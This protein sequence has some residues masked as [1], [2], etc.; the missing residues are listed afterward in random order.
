MNII[1]GRNYSG[2]TTL[3]RIFR[4]LETQSIHP[5]Y[6]NADFKITTSDVG[7]ITSHN[8]NGL[9]KLM[10]VYNVDFIKE[11]LSW[12]RTN[13]GTIV[14]F[15]VLGVTNVE[16]EKRI[17]EIDERMGDVSER[18]LLFEQ[19][20]KQSIY[21]ELKESINL[22]TEELT[23]RLR[24]KAKAIKN[25][26]SI[27]DT[28]VYTLTH[29]NSDIPNAR[30]ILSEEATDEKKMLIREDA[31]S[32]I[33]KLPENTPNFPL[34]LSKAEEILNRQIKPSEP[35]LELLNDNLLQEWVRR[36]IEQHKGVRQSCGFC[37]NP[38]SDELWKKLDS[39]FNKESEILR[40]DIQ[41][42][43]A[44]LEKAKQ[45]L[46]TFFT[47]SRELFYTSLHTKYD[48]L[49]QKWHEVSEA[50][51]DNIDKLI[52][53]LKLRE[54]DIFSEQNN[55]QVENEAENVV[56]LIKQFNYLVDENNQ[57]TQTLT[58]EKRAAR[59]M[60][61]LSDLAKF[62]RD[63][64][65]SNQYNNLDVLSR[66]LSIADEAYQTITD[67]IDELNEEKRTLQ[68][69]AK[70]ES[71]GAELVNKYLNHYFGHSELKLIAESET[72]I[73]KFRVCRDNKDATN[74]SE[75]ECSL[76]SFCY[77]IAKIEDE[78]K[79][80]VDKDSLIIYIDDPI[81]SLDSNHIFFMFS[82]IE[83]VI[84]NPKKYG[85]LFISTH[86]LDFLKYLKKLTVPKH[87]PFETSKEKVQDICHLVIERKS[88]DTTQI[89]LSPDYLKKYI[90]EFNYLFSQVYACAEEDYEGITTHHYQ[91]N[92][93]NNMRKFLEA[94]LFYKYPSH[95]LSL[96]QK[97]HKFF[98]N[99]AVAV[100]Q[101]NRLINE[102]SHLEEHADRGLEPIDAGAICKVAK[103]VIAQIKNND[104]HQFEALCESILN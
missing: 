104:P 26:T 37:G 6:Q 75:G 95:K 19:A 80:S 33:R 20:Q 29:I 96:G 4:C 15:T 12:L 1:Y 52:S 77:F 8:L 84:A 74:L 21:D 81:S 71:K 85:Q 9:N 91:Y 97:L 53:H 76:I 49:F 13:D 62:L 46:N 66:Q 18:G 67:V 50:Y 48:D 79:E 64:D 31:K 44:D 94:Y 11:N 93:G 69:Q 51:K 42:L 35:I 54:N 55:V 32:D 10:R 38:I 39:H 86:N 68:A 73:T 83:S 24:E 70:D 102:Y 88:K 14:P 57:K 78:M 58:A 101:I 5:D 100:N 99:D 60:L 72:G 28:P 17:K 25:N 82:L 92:F 89:K 63:I 40:K 87:K 61:R 90:T 2:K 45:G 65:Y 23:S 27:F 103:L 7:V 59:E 3:S 56:L 43:I 41:S 98:D 30:D 36:G 34:F 22:K 16:I 47:L